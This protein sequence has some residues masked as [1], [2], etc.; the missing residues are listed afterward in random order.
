MS[1]PISGWLFFML[2]SHLYIGSGGQLMKIITSRWLLYLF[3]VR[4]LQNLLY[5]PWFSLDKLMVTAP[6][7][8]YFPFMIREGTLCLQKP[9]IRAYSSSVHLLKYSFQ[10]AILWLSSYVLCL[11]FPSFI[12]LSSKIFFTYASVVCA[13]CRN[14]NRRHVCNFCLMNH[15]SHM[16]CKNV[17]NLSFRIPYPQRQRF[18]SCLYR[19]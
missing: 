17:Q 16:I 13:M 14:C 1:K 3:S 19:V 18:M 15:I 8:T 6:V 9:V 10:K 4:C 11:G 7:K 12:F 2:T 5:G